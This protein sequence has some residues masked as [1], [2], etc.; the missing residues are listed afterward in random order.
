MTNQNLLGSNSSW[1][2]SSF[3]LCKFEIEELGENL[4]LRE[5]DSTT[6]VKP[7]LTVSFCLF[8]NR[9]SG[10][11]GW[12]PPVAAQLLSCLIGGR[13]VV[14]WGRAGRVREFQLHT[15]LHAHAS[16]SEG[17]PETWDHEATALLF[18][19]VQINP[20]RNW[21]EVAASDW[22]PLST[23]NQL[24]TSYIFFRMCVVNLQSLSC[25]IR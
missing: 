18:G 21:Y 14:G 15:N 3:N 11:R 7:R 13:P 22:L 19:M 17:A 6:K 16:F 5:M 25:W 23:C 2:N 1:E 4:N 24:Q 20:S 9:G 8:W 12:S 10:C